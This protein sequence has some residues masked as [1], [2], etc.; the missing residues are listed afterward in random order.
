V[1]EMSSA[2]RWAIGAFLIHAVASSALISL[3]MNSDFRYR[4]EAAQ[5]LSRLEFAVDLAV[6]WL[7]DLAG[8]VFRAATS[9]W[10]VSVFSAIKAYAYSAYILLGAAFYGVIAGFLGWLVDRPSRG[11]QTEQGIS[12]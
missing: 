4:V 8:P 7:L 11:T 6:R 2:S 1:R 10:D 12:K 3:G 5:A 9:R